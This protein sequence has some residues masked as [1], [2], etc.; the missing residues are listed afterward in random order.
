M[1]RRMNGEGTIRQR[2]D[3]LY[4]VRITSRPDPS[5]GRKK[6]VSRYAKTREEALA[7]GD[8]AENNKRGLPCGVNRK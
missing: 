5:T 8:D 3:G 4:E 6:R 7:L 2:K 1:A